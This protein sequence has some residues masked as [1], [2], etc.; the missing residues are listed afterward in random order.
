MTD[1]TTL[2]IYPNVEYSEFWLLYQSLRFNKQKLHG[3]IVGIYAISTVNY[4]SNTIVNQKQSLSS[5]NKK[6]FIKV[7]K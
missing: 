2:P 6:Y 5:I 7:T 4:I 1:H 3:N